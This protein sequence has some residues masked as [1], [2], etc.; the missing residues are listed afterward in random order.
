MK[1]LLC[2]SIVMLALAGCGKKASDEERQAPNNT[3]IRDAPHNPATGGA[4]PAGPNSQPGTP[5][6]KIDP[7]P[8]PGVSGGGA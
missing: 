6:P 3:M 8:G 5:A 7:T 4:T 2:L 1:I